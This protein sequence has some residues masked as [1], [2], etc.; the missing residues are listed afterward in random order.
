MTKDVLDFSVLMSVYNKVNPEYLKESLNSIYE[1][2]KKPKE[3]ILVED[4]YINNE[5]QKTIVSFKTLDI[6][7]ISV[8]LKENEGL[9]SA[10]K[11][12]GEYVSTDLIARMDA[13][14]I[15]AK[16]RFELQLREFRKNSS[17]AIVGGQIAEF[18]DNIKNILSFRSVPTNDEDIRK[19][20]K[21]RSPFNHPTVML[22]KSFLEKAGGYQKFRNFEDYHL[23]VR[24]I[25]SGGSLVN[26]PNTLVYMRV[27]DDL[28]NRRGGVFYLKQ[29]IHLR[30][31]F[32]KWQFINLFEMIS[33]DLA[34]IISSLLPNRLRAS[35][36]KKVLR[37]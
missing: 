12:G 35:L 36:Y 13:D 34:M 20:A 28:Y 27:G 2:T 22:R 7:I 11:I 23:W 24:M 16:N 4:G 1:Q 14:D 21:L 31:L 26:I 8:R 6:P 5:I 18:S 19:F 37:K 30:Y 25:L 15:C 17:I 9:G 32:Y 3:I 29:Y 33:G 10:M